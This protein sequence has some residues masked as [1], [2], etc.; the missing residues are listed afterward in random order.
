M[1][2]N[3]FCIH[4]FQ[5]HPPPNVAL[6]VSDKE[7]LKE[8]RSVPA[9]VL[10]FRVDLCEDRS[11]HVLEQ[12]M[13]EIKR[14][15]RPVLLTFRNDKHEGASRS[16]PDDEKVSVLKALM[17]MADAVDVEL[18][19]AERKQILSSSLR[20]NICVVVSVHDFQT[21]PPDARLRQMMEEALMAKADILKIAVTPR[22]TE[23]VER[24]SGF[25][26]R[27]KEIPLITLAMGSD[28]EESRVSLAACG[29]LLTYTFLK[30]SA[31]PGQIPA[32]RL[33]ARLKKI[34]PAYAQ[35]LNLSK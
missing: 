17:P 27:V 34:Y 10:E 23:D 28:G 18:S 7:S 35:R 13:E 16:F 24:L 19:F 22:S 5:L 29:S 4:G 31:A 30:E 6:V 12:R 32:D 33:I 9:D 25:T 20:E 3:A 26:S 21:T 15:G 14:T 2:N 8:I 1:R 11:L